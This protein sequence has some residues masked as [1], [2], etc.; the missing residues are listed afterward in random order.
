[1]E[2]KNSSVGVFLR[3]NRVK[4]YRFKLC[5]L[6]GV[7]LT[8]STNPHSLYFFRKIHIKNYLSREFNF[9]AHSRHQA[10]KVEN[11]GSNA[12]SVDQFRKKVM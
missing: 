3:G 10:V 9:T 2:M 8:K 12:A 1:M 6:E 7:K 11:W 5:T 4:A